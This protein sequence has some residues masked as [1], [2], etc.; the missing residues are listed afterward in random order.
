MVGDRQRLTGALLNLARNAAQHTQP[1]DTIELGSTTL[2]IQ[3]RF[4]VRDTGEGIA[5]AD[6][7]RIFDR[8]ARAA[9]TYRKSEGAGLGLA[10][11]KTVAESHQ[12]TIELV[13]QPGTGST[14]T[15]VLPLDIP[16]QEAR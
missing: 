11:V 2:G 5:P 7:T 14:F 15:L 8:F 1:T 10:I 16:R 13:S 6:Q 9:N 12:G 4:W 3:V